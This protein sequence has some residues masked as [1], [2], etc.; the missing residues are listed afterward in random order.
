MTPG[1][2]SSSNSFRRFGFNG[3]PDLPIRTSIGRTLQRVAVPAAPNHSGAN[4]ADVI[5]GSSNALATKLD[6]FVGW[7][8]ADPG[9]FAVFLDGQI[10]SYA[11]NRNNEY[12]FLDLHIGADEYEVLYNRVVHQREACVP[13]DFLPDWALES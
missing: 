3:W 5:Q 8:G 1:P 10:E 13:G 9:D 6:L 2:S 4:P 11:L 7:S 12:W